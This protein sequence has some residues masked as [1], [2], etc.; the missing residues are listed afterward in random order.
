MQNNINQLRE[1]LFNAAR[2]LMSG[3]AEPAQCNALVNISNSIIA[4]VKSE[5]DYRRFLSDSDNSF[6]PTNSLQESSERKEVSPL[7]AIGSK[8]RIS[9]SN[10]IY[11]RNKEAIIKEIKPNGTYVVVTN[12]GER[13]IHVDN[14]EAL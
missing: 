14:L 3:K 10:D 4:S 7:F 8:V 9:K 6:F 2:D 12:L 13:T 11:I 1:L 5:I